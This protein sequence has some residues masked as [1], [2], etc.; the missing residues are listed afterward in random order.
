MR[1]IRALLCVGAM[2][3]FAASPRLEATTVKHFDLTGMTSS[4]ERVFRGTVTEVRAGTV[5]VG[6]GELT[7]VI[8]RI[9]VKE[10]FKGEFATFKDVTYADVEML[11]DIKARAGKEGVKHFSIFRDIPQLE[12]NKDYLLFLTAESRVALSSPV[13]LAQGC[14]E[15][16]TSIPSEPTANG[17]NNAGLAADLGRGAVPYAEIASRV[18]SLISG[19]GVK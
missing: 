6:G 15:I 11:G 12:Q 5:K 18:R 19:Q 4:A 16:D 2:A 7:T 3:A 14:F 8:Y 13:G 1:T 17:V 10:A 9:R